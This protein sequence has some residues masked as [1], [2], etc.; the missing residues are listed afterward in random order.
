MVEDDNRTAYAKW[1]ANR[2]T[3]PMK[4]DRSRDYVYGE[5]IE[6]LRG[7]LRNEAVVRDLGVDTK[8]YAWVD[9]WLQ[10]QAAREEIKTLRERIND[11]RALP[12]SRDEVRA[13]LD[14]ALGQFKEQRLSI[15]RN[16]LLNVQRNEGQPMLSFCGGTMIIPPWLRAFV[17]Q[18]LS[19]KEIDSLISDLDEGVSREQKGKLIAKDEKR[20]KELENLIEKE[21]SPRERWIHNEKGKPLGY[22]RGCRWFK[23]VDIWKK[24]AGQYTGPVDIK[25][26]DCPPGS[27]DYIA[28]KKLELGKALKRGRLY[29]PRKK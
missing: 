27:P 17:M 3:E 8:T 28:Y 22:P 19:K 18:G 7:E 14:E 23:F 12:R 20:I 1:E 5:S 2:G 24:V 26:Q 25:G 9:V 13:L 11:T 29:M 15:L 16:D 21:L 6:N 10:D 4:D